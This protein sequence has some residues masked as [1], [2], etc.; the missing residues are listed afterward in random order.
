MVYQEQ[1]P[2]VYTQN[3]IKA[4]M[5]ALTFFL[6]WIIKRMNEWLESV[7]KRV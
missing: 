5:F 7:L 2:K 1:V 6:V 3:K 4:L